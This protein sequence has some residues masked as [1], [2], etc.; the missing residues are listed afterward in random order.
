MVVL[1]A[2]IAEANNFAFFGTSLDVGL[3]LLPLIVVFAGKEL[4]NLPIWVDH[5]KRNNG[6]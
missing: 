5:Y 2:D 3:G 1:M 4:S 6:L